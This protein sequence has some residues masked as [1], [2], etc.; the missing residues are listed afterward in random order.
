VL[1]YS[2]SAKR[3]YFQRALKVWT[4]LASFTRAHVFLVAIVLLLIAW[5]GISW[6]VYRAEFQAQGANITSFSESLWWGVVTFLTVGYGDRYPI[7]SLGRVSASF[8]M[9]FGVLAVA[10]IT[11]KVSSFF[12]EQVLREGRRVVDTSKLKGHFVVC[13]WKEEMEE[14]LT[15]ILDFNPG[16][17]SAD[18]VLVANLSPAAL[19][20][21]LAEPRLKKLQIVNGDYFQVVHLKRA[22]PERARKV[23]ILADRSPGPTGIPVSPSE[24]DARTIMTAMTLASLARGT[25]VAAE[26][27]DPKM[28]QYLKIAQVSEVIYSREYSRLLLG[29]ATGGTGIANVI[30]SLLDPRTPTVISTYTVEERHLG[31]VYPQF[32]KEYETAHQDRV[33][34]GILEN[35]G[36]IHQIKELALRQ[37]QKTP[38]V[39]RL[40]ENLRGVKELKCNEPR[41]SPGAD[42]RIPEGS[43]VIVVE[44]RTPER[45]TFG[46]PGISLS[47]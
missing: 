10:L 41:F 8:L 47:S 31:V 23:L 20:T 26:I 5:V 24:T 37:A 32:K 43:M 46:S 42:Y 1:G 15:H 38:D 11:S 12:L 4:L 36:N 27:L 45:K 44:T 21:L 19:E 17:S 39:S 30:Y 22:A 33:V 2:S 29:N 6:V 18:L 40:V 13:G 25:P 14:L 16:M 28:D 9:L 7:T 3:S 35:T 34:I